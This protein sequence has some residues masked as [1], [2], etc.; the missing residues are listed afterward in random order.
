MRRAILG[1]RMAGVDLVQD[2]GRHSYVL[3]PLF[4]LEAT[5]VINSFDTDLLAARQPNLPAGQAVLAQAPTTPRATPRLSRLLSSSLQPSL[6][7]WLVTEWRVI[8]MRR[9][10]AISLA[11]QLYRA[12]HGSWPESLAALTPAYLPAVPLNPFRSWDEPMKYV[13]LKG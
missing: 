6:G 4:K 7:R 3:Q 11:A 12:D 2:V 10:A 9:A 13:I 5:H 1:E 8:A